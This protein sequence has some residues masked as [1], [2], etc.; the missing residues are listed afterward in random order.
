MQ[1]CLRRRLDA[2]AA[3]VNVLRT[4]DASNLNHALEVTANLPPV[5]DCEDSDFVQSDT[6]PPS[7]EAT[8]AA[9]ASLRAELAT[10]EALHRAGRSAD[11][12]VAAGPLISRAGALEY[13]PVLVD[14]LLV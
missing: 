1:I 7:N 9:V 13:S 2:M 11:A 12:L 5:A 3:A 10:V 6:E 8:R 14:A 4:I